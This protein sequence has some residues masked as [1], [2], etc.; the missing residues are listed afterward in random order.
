MKILISWTALHNDFINTGVNIEGPTYLFHKYYFNYDLHIILSTTDA[1]TKAVF[2][3]NRLKTDFP[4]HN[5]QI[6]VL[7]INDISDLKELKTKVESL[8]MEL[9]DHNIDIFFS[10][11]SS[12]M[13]VS[14]YICHTTLNLNTRLLQ[15]K[16]KEHSKQTDFPD[17]V[18]IQAV[19]SPVP[20]VAMLRQIN[21]NRQ[22]ATK[23]FMTKT[24]ESV[25]QKAEKVAH[26]DNVTVTIYGESGTGK[27]L[28][29]R[30]I[31]EQS[32][33]A[34]KPYKAINCSAFS[35]QLLE[36]RLFGYKKGSFTGAYSSEKG[37]FEEANHGTVFLDEIGDISAYMQQVLLRVIQEKEISPINKP[38]RK[39]DVRIIA[40]TNKNLVALCN[41]GKF[42]WDL[43][44]RLSVVE[45]EL[46]PL[47]AYT[48]K[49][50]KQLIRY[51]LKKKQKELLKANQLRL[52]S[53][54]ESVLAEYH[55]PGNIREM[56]NI[57]E[58]LYVFNEGELTAEDLPKQLSCPLQ[59]SSFDLKTIEQEHILK[60]FNHYK[61]NQRQTA[62]ALGIS[63][64]TLKTKLKQTGEYQN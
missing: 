3:E 51:F 31:H 8:L 61:R 34:A 22:D 5:I 17:L 38:S 11:G 60:V 21:L 33:R 43:Y 29:A 56:E 40:A 12:I 28:L 23:A 32:S 25:Y 44:Y 50:R 46:P 16:R 37:I 4:D 26:T 7:H 45:L 57:I 55:Y 20:H 2:L 15:L 13:Q 63:L 41:E 52:S 6:Q 42:R 58:S 18:E 36:S 9:K 48:G 59:K 10:P 54:A 24:L 19:Q 47:A 39:V 49:E 64:N 62:L 27:E 14:W 30:F 53:K 1:E 35:D